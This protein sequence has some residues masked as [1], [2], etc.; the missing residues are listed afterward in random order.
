MECGPRELWAEASL[1]GDE[2]GAEDGEVGVEVDVLGAGSVFLEEGVAN[3]V[4]ADFAAAPVAADQA[5]EEGGLAGMVAAEVEATGNGGRIAGTFPRA[6]L[7]DDDQGADL[8]EPQIERLSREDLYV[9]L[10]DAS[11]PG[12]GAAFAKRGG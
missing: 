11:V 4:V 3:P 7:L 5:G 1:E 10:V 9:T 2:G 8:R 6:D 12:V